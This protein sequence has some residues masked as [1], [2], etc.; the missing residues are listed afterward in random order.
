M[1]L[2]EIARRLDGNAHR[3]LA[4]GDDL[5]AIP[6]AGGTFQ[7]GPSEVEQKLETELRAMREE[8]ERERE[9]VERLRRAKLEIERRATVA[10]ARLEDRGPGA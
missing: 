10:E 1:I 7:S 5:L 6:P 2:G 9:L 4:G 8:L 3:T